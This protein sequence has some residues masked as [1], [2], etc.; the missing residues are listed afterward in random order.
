MEFNIYGIFCRTTWKV[1]YGS[2]KLTVE[3]R[4][5]IHEKDYKYYFEGCHGY[6]SAF[7]VLKNN[8]Y[9]IKLLE[10]CYDKFHMRDR[11]NF[12]IDNFPCVNINRAGVPGRTQK[13]WYKD[14]RQKILER[15]K[16][17]TKKYYEANKEKIL[18]KSKETYN[19][20]CGSTDIRKFN[21]ARHETSKKHKKYLENL[22]HY[23][24][25]WKKRLIL[26]NS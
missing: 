1:Y 15:S 14:N 19:C 26:K 16:K 25:K 18:Q 20:P 24:N 8:Y 13:E 12:Y 5:G 6:Y 22:K 7:E 9:E 17:Y 2:T 4:L 3:Q 11:E 21:K 23:F 10:K